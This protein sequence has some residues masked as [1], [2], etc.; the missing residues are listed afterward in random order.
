[1]PEIKL[2]L[3]EPQEAFVFSEAPH[4]ALVAGYGAGKS[5][6]AVIRL[7][8]K[9]LEYPGMDFG[10]VEPTY[11]LVKLIAWPRFTGILEGWGIEH[12]LNKSD[13]VLKIGNG[14]QI[15][16]RSAD[17]VD[18][19]VGFEIADG[20]IDEIDTLKRDH[21]ADVWTKMLAR[22]RQSKPDGSANTLAAASTPEGFRFVYETWGKSAK[23]GYDLI[24]APTSSNPYLPAGYIDQLRATY[25]SSQ[26]QAYLDGEFVNLTAGSVYAEFD[27]KLNLTLETIQPGEHIHV[28]MDF[29]V[30]NMT[31]VALVIRGNNPLALD[32]VTQVRDTPAMIQMLKQRYAG[33]PVTVYPD[34]SGGATKSV[35]ASLSD[36]TLLRGAGFTVLAHSKNPAVKDRVMAV[37]QMIHNQGQ[38]RLLINPDK[39]PTLIEGLEQQ[40]YN[41]NGE[42][43]KANGLDHAVDALGYMIAYK[44]GIGRGTVQFTQLGGI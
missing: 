6:A 29:N 27:R 3:T 17:N 22:C 37:N 39:C 35:N 7:L 42:P 2:S 26:L 13:S 15:I 1:M 38:R 28:G 23:P 31:A 14:S 18:R 4:P 30:N 41:K 34:A 44:F 11:D 21:A 8:V 5:Q 10:F 20:V 24:K 40:A 33:H 19:M 43:D 25:S 36:I 16:F 32:E 9:A 12:E